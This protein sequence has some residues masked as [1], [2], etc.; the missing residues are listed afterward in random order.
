LDD[1]TSGPIRQS[2]IWQRIGRWTKPNDLIFVEA[3]TAQFGMPDAP[4]AKN[5]QSE[6][7]ILW[8]SIGYTV[9]GLLGG[10]IAHR[11]AKTDGRVILVVG[12]GR[13][14]HKNSINFHVLEHCM[15]DVF[16]QNIY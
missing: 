13:C 14:V 7:Q 2:Y 3:G 4:L 16:L 12:D 11:E 8:S 5:C 6:T 1:S 15:L 10:L 9:G